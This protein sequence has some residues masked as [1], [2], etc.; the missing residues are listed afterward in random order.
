MD[1][2]D[3]EN[4]LAIIPAYNEAENIGLVISA[5]LKH[6]PV[7]VIDDGSSDETA[8]IAAGNGAKVLHQV[9]N[10]GKGVALR[11]GFEH[12]IEAGYQA[13]VTLDADGQHDPDEV[14]HIT[15]STI[16]IMAE[17]QLLSITKAERHQFYG[18]V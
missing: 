12:A 13:V 17:Y 7:L 4:V 2:S 11:K 16:N 1:Q 3:S 5:A 18:S 15:C 8:R 10:Q 9:P 14:A 6:L